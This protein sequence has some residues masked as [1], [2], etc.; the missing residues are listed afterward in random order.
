MASV[1]PAGGNASSG[2]DVQGLVGKLVSAD[3][4][5]MDARLTRQEVQVQANISALGTFRASLAEFQNSLKGLRDTADLHKMTIKSSNDDAVE[6]IASKEAQPGSYQ[7]EVRQLAR[8]QRLV[9]AVF[10][11]DL[12]PV[13]TGK[14]TF[15]FGKLNP[16]TSNFDIN[17]KSIPQ[18][19]EISDSN[20]SLRGIK[21]TINKSDFG[22]RA[23][24]VNDGSGY[25]LVLTSALTGTANQ[26]RI[27]VDDAANG[28]SGSDLALLSYDVLGSRNLEE[29]AAAD[30]AV[31]SL[32]GIEVSSPTNQI[33]N[34]ITGLTL[35]LKN[36]TNN[37]PVHVSTS[38]DQSAVLDAVHGFVKSYNDLNTTMQSI[39]G[40]DQ[41]TKQ[42]GPLAGDPTVRGIVEQLRRVIGGSF[43]G[44]NK[45]YV[46]LAS[47]GI[48]SQR[49]GTLSI[50]ESKLQNAVAGNFTEIA[51]LFARSGSASDPLVKF[52][53]A[54]EATAMGAYGLRITQLPKH[55]YYIGAENGGLT[56][57]AI[58]DADNK[59]VVKVDGTT[60]APIALTPGV[61]TTGNELA[62]TLAR[63]INSD[64]AIKRA[65][66]SVTVRV[67]ADQLVIES[68][69]LG[70]AS[71]LEI[72]SADP[73][74][75]SLGLDPAVGIEGADI[76]GTL[77][78]Q[79]AS[80]SGNRLIGEQLAA[81]LKVEL[82]GGKVGD[83]GEV[84]FSR[85]VAEQ[86][87]G[88]L[89]DF[90]G[91]Q[92]IIGTRSKGY[93][94]RIHD[95]GQQRDQMDRRLATTEQRLLKQ[96]SSLDALLGKMRDTST[97]L[98]THLPGADGTR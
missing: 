46:S 65:G 82:L 6:V 71:R 63:Q 30:D 93:D 12:D 75:K 86:L 41:K 5:P 54:K 22:V 59:L 74:I 14:L 44:I 29:T 32:D 25:R 84:V 4:A 97:Y 15:Q 52:V 36:T 18:V 62:A 45:E 21:E 64:A 77:G 51:Q 78:N 69:R 26:M 89:D 24:I 9:S 57:T 7:L 20:N 98:S 85:G 2:L 31:I 35:K 67:I 13:G 8:A 72:V 38:F 50:D 70:S 61:Y 56:N 55:G 66:S 19:I 43:G 39:A 48:D 16:Q 1:G 96:Y 90:L 27:L 40:V 42:A 49:N 17:G 80:G 79:P 81:G 28:Q 23:S 3:R 83:R 88:L 53:D 73:G 60:S 11:S 37:E 95:I 68:A 91:A 47:I 10:S 94:A 87:N 92:G 34:A 76:E 58:T 33:D